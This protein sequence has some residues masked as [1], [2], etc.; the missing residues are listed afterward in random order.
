[1]SNTKR[2]RLTDSYDR[3]TA[4]GLHIEA[5]QAVELH[6]DRAEPLIE[7]EVLERAGGPETDGDGDSEEQE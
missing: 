3:Y 4:A 1:M 7:R 6:P 5:G 2:Y